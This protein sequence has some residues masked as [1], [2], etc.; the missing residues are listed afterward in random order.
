MRLWR[1]HFDGNWYLNTY[2]DVAEG[3]MEPFEHFLKYGL[4]EGRQPGPQTPIRG[5][6]SP[7][8]EAEIYCHKPPA[9]RGEVALFAT[10]SPNGRLKPHVR[11]YL[12]CLKRHNIGVILIVAADQPFVS[13]ADLVSVIDGMFVRQNQ[14][15]DFAAW[16]HVLRLHPELIDARILYLLNDSVFGPTNDASFGRLLRRLRDS[17]ADC[18]GLTE[19]YVWSWHYQSYFLAFKPRALRSSVFQKFIRDIV[20]FEDKQDVINQYELRV[21]WLLQTAGLELNS[22]LPRSAFRRPNGF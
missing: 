21:A 17:R 5:S 8:T 2:P 3:G 18:I 9:V 16:A 7:V 12:D 6:S 4:K 14:G 20:S 19:N 11:H 10:Y 15:Y 13:E 1:E 22:A